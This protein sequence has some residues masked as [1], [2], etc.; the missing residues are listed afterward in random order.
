MNFADTLRKLRKENNMT[1]EELAKFLNVSSQTISKWETSGGYPDVSLLPRI[2]SFFGISIDE[3]LGVSELKSEIH[4][5]AIH[6]M[7]ERN[8]RI[9]NHEENIELLRQAIKLFPG[10]FLLLAELAVSLEKDADENQKYEN[11]FEA[12]EISERIIKF[13]KDRTLCNEIEANICF[14]YGKAGRK[15]EAIAAAQRLPQLTKTREIMSLQLLPDNQ[16]KHTAQMIIAFS[17]WAIQY[18][19]HSLNALSDYTDAEK[20]SLLNQSNSVITTLYPEPFL[21]SACL[22]LENNLM[23]IPLLVNSDKVNDARECISQSIDLIKSINDGTFSPLSN[24][25]TM[26]TLTAD[27]ING[28]IKKTK[29]SYARRLYDILQERNLT[30]P[31]SS[32]LSESIINSLKSLIYPTQKEGSNEVE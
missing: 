28:Y 30:D 25:I 14:L 26:N 2:S 6:E 16:K 23:L 5:N 27:E 19:A 10:D 21:L 18:A 24:T 22:M 7:W 15:D 9:Q 32:P 13:C 1:Q 17:V 31:Q 8:N 20:I 12:I 3:L 4:I 11:Y 29:N